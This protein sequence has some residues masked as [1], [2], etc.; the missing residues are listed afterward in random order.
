MHYVGQ[1]DPSK[2]ATPK[3]FERHSRGY[4]RVPLVDHTV[5]SVHTGVG[6]C[7]LQPDGRVNACV[8]ANEKGI[9]ILDGEVEMQR[10]H[11]VFRLAADDY[12]LIPYGIPYALRNT[13]KKAVHWYEV[14]APQP[15]PIGGWQDTFFIGDAVWSPEVPAPDLGDPRTRL[16]GHFQEVRPLRPHGAGIQG[17]TVYRFME[18]E[19]GAQHFFLMRGELAEGGICG[20]HDHPVEESYFALSGEADM[21]IEGERFHLVRRDRGL[22]GGW[23]EPC[24]FSAGSGAF[25]LD[26]DAGSPISRAERVSQLRGVEQ[27]T[28]SLKAGDKERPPK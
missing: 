15:K 14:Q 9:Y 7:R 21:E 22:D 23:G 4:E 3:N 20:L 8:H 10:D 11:E 25:P 5:G 17:L 12:A 16:L 13:A 26:G 18:R 28:E 2:F 6:I 27:I 19:F 1:F 24:L